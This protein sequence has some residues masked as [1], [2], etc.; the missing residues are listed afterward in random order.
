MKVPE[1][2]RRAALKSYDMRTEGFCGGH[3]TGWKRAKQLSSEE[4]ISIE[5]LRFMRNWYARHIHTSYPS[6]LE[7]KQSRKPMNNRY[8]HKKCGIIAW[9]IWGGDPGLTWVNNK[10][11]I[12]NSY[13]GTKYE[14]I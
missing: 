2:V 11:S 4:Y 13:F 6:Y 9:Q 1:S 14:K 7:W 5:D 3:S 8:F 12:L 10:T